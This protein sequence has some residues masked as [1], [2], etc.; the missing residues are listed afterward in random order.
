M[1]RKPDKAH[2][3]E[4]RA[5]RQAKAVTTGKA[6]RRGGKALNSGRGGVA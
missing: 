1:S 5:Q 4:R 2:T 3:L 6:Y